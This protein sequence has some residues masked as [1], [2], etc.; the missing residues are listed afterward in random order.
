VKHSTRQAYDLQ[1]L[2]NSAA[3]EIRRMAESKARHKRDVVESPEAEQVE[4]RAELIDLMEILTR[5][6]RDVTDPPQAAPARGRGS[7]PGRKRSTNR[8]R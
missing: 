8:R 5:S 6:L 4:Q 3:D 7:S 1:S 2:S